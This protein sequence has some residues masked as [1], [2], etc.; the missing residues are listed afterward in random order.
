MGDKGLE[1]NVDAMLNDK[2]SAGLEG[3]AIFARAK[4]VSK[5]RKFTESMEVVVKLNVDPT[6]GDQNIRGT[7]ILP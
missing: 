2:E 7:C 4:E 1:G 3:E 6:Q 5:E